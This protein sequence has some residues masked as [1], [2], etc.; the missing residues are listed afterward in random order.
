MLSFD[1]DED[2]Q[3]EIKAFVDCADLWLLNAEKPYRSY[4]YQVEFLENGSWHG[5]TSRGE[6]ISKR[7]DSWQ[8]NIQTMNL[9]VFLL[10]E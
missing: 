4:S 6:K 7:L 5:M 8:V 9:E 10:D 1:A 2:S 3:P